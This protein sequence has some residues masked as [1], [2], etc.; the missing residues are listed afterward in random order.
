MVGQLKSIRNCLRQYKLNIN[1][2][3]SSP[4]R[5]W[6]ARQGYCRDTYFSIRKAF[7]Q[8]QLEIEE[9][10]G[11]GI[12]PSFLSA[13]AKILENLSIFYPIKYFCRV[14]LFSFRQKRP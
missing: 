13:R 8:T 10:S 5:F 2:Y 9:V 12:L 7:N 4:R 1:E 11:A 14:I 6:I 3:F